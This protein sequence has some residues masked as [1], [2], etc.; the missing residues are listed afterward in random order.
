MANLA[1]LLMMAK[2]GATQIPK[3]AER[4][5]GEMGFDSRFDDRI[6]EQARLK[7]LTTKVQQTGVDEVPEISLADF[8]GRPFI[9][10][11]SDRTGAGGNL[12]G[13][14]GTELNRPVEL[15]GGQDYMFNNPGQV[16]ASAQSPVK[17][18]MGRAE[19]IKQVT[20][21]NPLFIPWRMAPSGGDFAHMTGETMINYLDSTLGK[22]D[23]NRV[24]KQIRTM[25]PTWNGLEADTAIDQFRSSPDKV[26]K[27]LKNMLDVNYRD[28]GGLSLGEARLSVA[29]PKQLKA[30]DAGIM[31]VGEIFA[32][33]PMIHD[34]GHP[35]YPRGVP[36]QGLGRLKQDANIFDL[37]PDVVRARGMSDVK[38][39]SQ[40][41]IRAMQM[42]PYAGVLTA[43][44]LKGLGL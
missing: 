19:A 36:G 41:D 18:I 38:N 30:P 7:G 26:R 29:D 42:K 17:Q 6:K 13:I 31:N 34:S 37:L 12:L 14:N 35:S 23:R 20:G 21:Q 5:I 2:E 43:E 3:I 8:E 28:N 15:L 1:K 39:P 22:R 24:N 10:T 27:A 33:N 4:A 32:N 40:T 44:L 16:W 25:I 11:M 9:T